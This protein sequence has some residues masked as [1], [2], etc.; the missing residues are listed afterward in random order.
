VFQKQIAAG[1]VVVALSLPT[2]GTAGPLEDGKTAFARGDYATAI[3]LWRP[4]ADQGLADAQFGLGVI[5]AEGRGVPKDYADALIWY[6]KA[7][8]QGYPLAQFGLAV[9]YANG[10]G[11]PKDNVS[12][13]MWLDLAAESGL[14]DAAESRDMITAVMT[15]AQV[16]EA[17]MRAREWKPKSN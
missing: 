9:M 10:R 13:L 16:A 4:L 1:L 12:A 3:Q 5:Y 14:T 6:R 11:V 7:A 2:A 15:A 8:D 17:Q